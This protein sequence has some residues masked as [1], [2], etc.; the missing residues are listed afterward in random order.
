MR[1]SGL[2]PSAEDLDDDGPL[3]RAIVEV[4]QDQLLPGAEGEAAIEDR[5]R[6]RG[7]D[8][9]RQLVGVG[10]GVVVEPVVLVIREVD[11]VGIPPRGEPQLFSVNRHVSTLPELLAEQ[12]ADRR[13]H[14]TGFALYLGIGESDHSE[15]GQLQR[16]VAQSIALE[17]DR[18]VMKVPAVGF[19]YE[20]LLR[21]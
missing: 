7:T 21:P 17:G 10:V 13:G 18:V 11:H 16:A 1:R 3:A 12:A 19:D 8:P 5:D 4:D 15:P 14:C 2:P 6:L 9:R 20:S